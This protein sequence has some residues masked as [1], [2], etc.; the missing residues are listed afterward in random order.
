ME[1]YALKI[2]QREVGQL[3][4]SVGTSLAL[5]LFT[6]RKDPDRPERFLTKPTPPAQLWINLRTLF[7]NLYGAIESD[8]KHKVLADHFVPTLLNEIEFIKTMV[9]E[10]TLGRTQVVFYHCTYKDL[11]T[12]FP[13]AIHKPLNTDNQKIYFA[14]EQGACEDVIKTLAETNPIRQFTSKLQ[15]ESLTT[16][17]LSHVPVDLVSL[18]RF[19]RVTLLESHTAKLKEKLDWNTKLTGGSQLAHLPFNAFTLQLF[20]DG[21]LYFSPMPI[22]IKR[23]VLALAETHKWTPATSYE[24]MRYSIQSLNDHFTKT[25]LLSLMR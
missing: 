17:L 16:W 11:A 6:D 19:G 2:A 20:G 21:G 13:K 22:K 1:S 15:G 24:K 5:E 18:D 8:L 12:R 3:P 23:E 25:W 10:Q 7:R 9:S 4:L 14:T